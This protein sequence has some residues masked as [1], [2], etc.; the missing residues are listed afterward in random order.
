MLVVSFAV[1]LVPFDPDAF[2]SVRLN[3]AISLGHRRKVG[4]GV[5]LE[6]VSPESLHRDAVGDV[7]ELEGER[8]VVCHQG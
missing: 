1:G 8:E 4:L 6:I 7:G 2:P 5:D 3:R